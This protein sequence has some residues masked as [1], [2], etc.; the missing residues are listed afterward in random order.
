M[1]NAL[2]IVTEINSANGI[3]SKAVMNELKNAG[4]NVLCVCNEERGLIKGS[5][6]KDGIN[7]YTVHPRLTYRMES[8]INTLESG[9]KKKIISLLRTVTDKIKLFLSVP[10]WP[11][12]SPSYTYRIY[13]KANTLCRNEKIDIIVP[14]YTKMDTMI[15]ARKI[16]KEN[17]QIKYY[18]YFLDSLSGGFGPRVFSKEWVIKRGLKW[19][20]RLL[21]SADKIIMMKS[22]E[23]H[24]RQ[25]SKNRPYYDKMVFLD[26]PLF[27]PETNTSEETTEK[28]DFT[29]LL[30]IGTIPVQVRNPQKFFKVFRLVEG[31][32]YRLTIVGTNNCP[33]LMDRAAKEDERICFRPFV[34]HEEAKA[35][36]RSADF[37][38]NFGNNDISMTPSKIFEYM[39]T[40]RPIISTSPI[41]DEPSTYYLEKYPLSCILKE[42]CD[43]TESLAEQLKNFLET[44]QGKKTDAESLERIFSL[45]TPQ[46]FI[47]SISD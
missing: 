46:A 8:Y 18:P 39:S 32:K 11:L 40:G 13:K 22:S 31:E 34:S 15:A 38:V 10:T 43:S 6:T 21:N 20:K 19:E 47:E 42:Y 26:L 16:K 27:I 35:L 5:Y 25:Y 7:Y 23:E 24:H 9:F 45:N 1:K 44:A 12:I 36:M 14:V 41:E 37:L 30:F 17:P 33:G 28:R 3:C 4:Y 2:F 29:E